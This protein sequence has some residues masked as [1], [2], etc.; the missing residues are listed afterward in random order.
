MAF[1]PLDAVDLTAYK[2]VAIVL[3][4]TWK[5]VA[6][7]CQIALCFEREF[8]TFSSFLACIL[9][10]SSKIN[11]VIICS[12]VFLFTQVRTKPDTIQKDDRQQIMCFWHLES[13][14]MSWAVC[15]RVILL[16]E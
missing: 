13:P 1:L 7:M 14:L 5:N 8:A 3:V 2:R 16:L 15:K 12:D 4:R 10:P 11:A 9:T 6:A